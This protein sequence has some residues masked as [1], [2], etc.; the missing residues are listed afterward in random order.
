MK[1]KLNQETNFIKIVGIGSLNYNYSVYMTKEEALK[2]NFDVEKINNIK[3]AM[4]LVKNKLNNR[5]ILESNY[6]MSLLAFINKT[7]INK[8]KFSS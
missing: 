2:M 4:S 8:K 7:L 5:I 1:N 3:E 6:L